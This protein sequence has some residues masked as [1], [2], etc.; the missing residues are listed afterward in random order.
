LQ[1]IGKQALLSGPSPE[2]ERIT[3]LAKQSFHSLSLIV[4]PDGRVWYVRFVRGKNIKEV[5]WVG[6]NTRTKDMD[7]FV[8]REDRITLVHHH[9][10]DHDN[11]P[12][13]ATTP[14]S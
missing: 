14:S 2:Q 1:I 9:A 3:A 13:A 8:L 5:G 7:S 11:A 12:G 10:S 6:G 4:F